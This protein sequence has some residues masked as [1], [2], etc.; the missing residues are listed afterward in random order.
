MANNPSIT[1]R[2]STLDSLPAGVYE[3]ITFRPDKYLRVWQSS[4]GSGGKSFSFESEYVVKL[5]V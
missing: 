3:V 2:T 1:V 5:T 4:G